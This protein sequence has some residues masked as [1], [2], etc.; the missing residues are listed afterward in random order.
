MEKLFI[1]ELWLEVG[2]KFCCYE[3][4]M[5]YRVG[6]IVGW[7]W[8]DVGLFEVFGKFGLFFGVS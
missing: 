8:V 4:K 3:V 2:L 1:F 5:C 6:V 7:I